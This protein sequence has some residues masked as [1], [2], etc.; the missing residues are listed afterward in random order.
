M[1]KQLVLR[2]TRTDTHATWTDTH[3][4]Q[5]DTYAAWM[6]TYDLMSDK[7]ITHVP[8][9]GNNIATCFAMHDLE[10]ALTK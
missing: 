4:T 1:V 3:A 2:C 6:D 9:Q 8:W 5:T 7:Y 10:H